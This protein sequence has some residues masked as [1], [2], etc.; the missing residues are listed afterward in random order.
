MTEAESAHRVLE[1]GCGTGKWLAELVRAGSE[2]SGIDPSTEMLTRAFSQAESSPGDSEP[3]ECV[4]ID[5]Q[6]WSGD[7]ARAV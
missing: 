4:T 6:A 5:D 3:T 2:V 7:A 1:V